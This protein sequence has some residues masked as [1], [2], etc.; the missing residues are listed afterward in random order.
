M[1]RLLCTVLAALLLCGCTAAP[2]GTTEPAGPVL[3]AG[4]YLPTN[5]E[6]EGTLLYIQLREDGTGCVS[7]LGM[8]SELTWA[9]EGAVFGEMTITPTAGGLLADYEAF[10]YIGERL[11]EG[12]LPD[13][14]EPGVW[15]VSSVGR[16]GDVDFYGNL[17]RSNGYFELKEDNTGVLVFDD[18]EYPFTLEGTTARFDGWSVMLVGMSEGLPEGEEAMAMIYITDGPIQADSI[19]FRKMEE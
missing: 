2:A 15:A 4:F 17:S 11:P 6:L 14:P 7:V 13:P 5:A 8:I 9:P 16:D 12:Y 1:K 3:K 18:A 19:A 10:E